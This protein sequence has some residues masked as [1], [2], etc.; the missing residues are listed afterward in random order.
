MLRVTCIQVCVTKY[1][2]SLTKRLST[3]EATSKNLVDSSGLTGLG[4]FAR[5]ADRNARDF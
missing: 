5:K 4:K 3:L 2:S 1:I